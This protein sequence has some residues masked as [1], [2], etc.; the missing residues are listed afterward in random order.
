M[1]PALEPLRPL[2]IALE[3]LGRYKLRTALSV[4][5]V[6]LGV[7]G[8]VAMTSVSQG[9]RDEALRQVGQLGL[10]NLVVRRR[11]ATRDGAGGVAL[12]A[13]D[14]DV[15]VATVPLVSSASPLV[16]RFLSV[17]YAGRREMATVVGV[18]ASYQAILRL[19]LAGGRPLTALDDR[20][21]N[22]ACVVGQNLAKSLFRYTP[23]I[24][25]WIRIGADYF[26]VVGVIDTPAGGSGATGS[27]AWRDISRSAIVPLSALE[28]R[29]VEIAPA[30]PVD[31]IWVRVTDGSRAV[32][33]GDVLAHTM[34]RLHGSTDAVDVIVP[35]ELL[36]Q[37]YR[38]QQT[39][40]VV[41]GSVA[42]LALI[43]GGIGIMNI[44]LTSVLERTGEIGIRRAVGAARRDIAA[45]F[46]TES[47]LMTLGGGA[48]GI[49]VGAAISLAITRYAEW[50]TRV[51]WEA[52]LLG[53]AVS[54]AIGVVFG[55]YPAVRA[56]R[57]EPVVALH[58]E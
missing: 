1:R 10:D 50:H 47:L 43:V 54:F 57:L 12:S 49:G 36:A 22:R 53:F 6:V 28:G 4:L 32:E 55:S 30:A 16:E 15:L 41:V 24:G 35:R 27:I 52:V 40:A 11:P 18:R 23:A 42:A 39:F 34:S 21:G 44:M 51:S 58:Y 19:P 2:R 8:V 14:A 9:A 26:E 17:A 3:A 56:S 29:S 7:A 25:Q 48:L 31:E 13:A 20:T 38:T 37:R 5:G 33:V 46:L 45:Q